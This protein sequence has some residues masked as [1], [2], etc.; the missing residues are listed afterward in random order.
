MV[1]LW[2]T[3]HMQPSTAL[4]EFHP[5]LPHHHGSGSSLP[6][7]PAQSFST[8]Q[9]SMHNYPNFGWNQG[10]GHS[11]VLT[12]VHKFMDFNMLAKHSSMNSKK[13]AAVPSILVKEFE[14]NFQDCWKNHQLLDLFVTSFSVNINIFICEFSKGMFWV[15][16]KNLIMFLYKTF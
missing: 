4:Q 14:N 1:Y 8:N 12:V 6:R 3:G 7:S 2:P 5:L 15:A 9:T 16:I 13:Y 11:A 10:M